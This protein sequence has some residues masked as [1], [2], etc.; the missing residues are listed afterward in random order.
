MK[1]EGRLANIIIRADII[2][3]I[4]DLARI[5]TTIIVRAV[6]ITIVRVVR[7]RADITEIIIRAVKDL[8]TIT[9]RVVTTI[10]DIITDPNRA[11]L[12]ITDALKITNLTTTGVRKTTGIRHLSRYLSARSN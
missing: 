4:T 1:T 11:D 5:I 8:I 10:T 7:I 2:K 3:D 12:I 9:V 6:I